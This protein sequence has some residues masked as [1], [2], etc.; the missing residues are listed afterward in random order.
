MRDE[1]RQHMWH[2]ERQ[3]APDIGLR[4][5]QVT[6]SRKTEFKQRFDAAAALFQCR[7]E[8]LPRYAAAID[9]CRRRDAML[10]AKRRDPHASRVV[11]MAGDH[12]NRPSW[13]AWNRRVPDL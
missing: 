6:S 13:R 1:I 9:R 3:V 4:S 11:Q 10:T 2:V 5:R 8:F 7:E 12:P